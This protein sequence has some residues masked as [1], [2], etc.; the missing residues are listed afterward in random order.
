M[1]NGEEKYEKRGE[2]IQYS[3]K[4][5]KGNLFQIVAKTLDKCR[6]AKNNWLQKNKIVKTCS[7]CHSNYEGMVA[8]VGVDSNIYLGKR[9]NYDDRGKY[10]NE[11]DSLYFISNN[12]QIYYFLYGDGYIKSQE[13]MLSCGLTLDD[14]KEFTKVTNGIL[15]KFKKKKDKDFL[16]AGKAF[17]PID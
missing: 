3:Y 4:T 11:D 5:N 9:E 7:A 12:N 14:Y 13:E 6:E 17:K 15:K 2:Y 10:N 8:L 16:F 1:K